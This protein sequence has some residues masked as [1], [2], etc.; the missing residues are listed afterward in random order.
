MIDLVLPIVLK[1]PSV[2]SV[3]SLNPPLGSLCSVQYL[4][5]SI[6]L[7]ICQALAEP[8]R[9]Q[10]YQA[11]INKQL[12]AFPMMFGFGDCL[13]DVSPGGAVSG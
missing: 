2:P 5:A 3:L 9:R 1:T 4:A 11:P 7:Y 13:W 6:Y 8:L 12:L 10:I